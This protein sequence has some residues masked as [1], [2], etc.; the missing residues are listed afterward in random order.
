MLYSLTFSRQLLLLLLPLFSLLS[1]CN[2]FRIKEEILCWEIFSRL[3]TSGCR[4]TG[5]QYTQP[6]FN[7]SI[8][9]LSRCSYLRKTRA[10]PV[11]PLPRLVNFFSRSHSKMLLQRVSYHTFSLMTSV[12]G[13][14]VTA[15]GCWV[16]S[17]VSM[18]NMGDIEKAYRYCKED[19]IYAVTYRDTLQS[20]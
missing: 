5:S 11:K 13:Q 8:W 6:E 12:N 7:T 19:Y 18:D 20:S 10:L 4:R 16:S 15:G 9:K 2:V 17:L 1:S 3:C 14:L